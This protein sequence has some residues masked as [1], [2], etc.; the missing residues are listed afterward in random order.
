MNLRNWLTYWILAVVACFCG[1]TLRAQQEGG[2]KPKPAARVLVPLPDLNGQQDEDQGSENMQPDNRP[3][4]GFQD[5]TL[6]TSQ[7][8]HSYWVPGV[9]YSNTS[10]SGSTNP[11]LNSGWITTNYVNGNISMLEAWSHNLLSASY[12]GGGFFSQDKAQGN[13]QF[14]QLATAFEIDRQRWQALLVDEYSYLPQSSF[15][16]GGTSGLSFPGITGTLAVPLPGLQNAFLPGQSILTAVG[17]RYSNA[18]AAQLTF[19][20]SKRGSFVIGGV[21]GLLRFLS[22]GNSDNDTEIF[23][24][25]YNY[26]MTKKDTIGLDY[27]FSAYHF[28]GAAQAVGDHVGQLVYGRR[29]TGRLAMHIGGGPEVTT[30]RVPIGGSARKISGTG[31]ASLIYSFRHSNV[32]LNY[33]HGVTNGS[34]LF[35]GANTD[36]V[37][38]ALERRLSRVWA[39]SLTFG[40]AKNQQI[41]S[42]PGLTSPI[43]GSWIPGA[44]LTRPLGR[45]ANLSL[46]YQAQ[47]QTSNLPLCNSPTCGTNYTT[48]QV[49]LSFQW[50]A[51]PQVLR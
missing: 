26:L 29:I 35:S 22:P 5:F 4:T 34:G 17:P 46:G 49:L 28:P 23:N 31:S 37:I 14:H 21:H 8:R 11:A 16:F 13:G 7:L 44:G 39:G 12:S 3:V 20:V 41:L 27:R 18:S 38:A 45:T 25:G 33:M 1:A 51:A 40:Y 9:Q 30:F 48:H 47:I 6:G 24:A 10:Q 32:M 42:I 19:E 43:F 2:D 15:G 50:H 36:L